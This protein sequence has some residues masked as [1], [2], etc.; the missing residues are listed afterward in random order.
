M[1]MYD[2]II[3][4]YPLRKYEFLQNEV[5]QTKDF[6]NLMDIYK[7]TK[8]RRLLLEE[9]KYELVPEKERPYYGTEQWSKHFIF[10]I[11]GSM[12]RDSLGWKDVN[13][14]GIFTF[15]TLYKETGY[16]KRWYEFE[17]KFTNGNLIEI[18]LLEEKKI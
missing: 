14:H 17:A 10:Q 8:D 15:Y 2:E 3:V 16:K 5:F 6:N 9:V 1:G 12:R 13:Y 7:I 18:K 4:E 11:A